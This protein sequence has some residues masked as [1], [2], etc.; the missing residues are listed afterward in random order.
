[1]NDRSDKEI[2]DEF[3]KKLAEAM[4]RKDISFR[5]LSALSGLNLGNLSDLATGKRNPTLTTLVRLAQA[6]DISP[7]D[8]LPTKP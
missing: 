7:V 1:M 6:L 8:L 3:A 4:K 2:I 5:D